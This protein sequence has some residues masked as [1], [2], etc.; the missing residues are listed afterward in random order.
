MR[1][2]VLT[3]FQHDFNNACCRFNPSLTRLQQ[4]VLPLQPVFNTTSTVRVAGLTRL[5]PVF[6]LGVEA[7]NGDFLTQIN[8]F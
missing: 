4:C 7:E 5:Q 8:Q 1:V 2:A 3:R 6:S